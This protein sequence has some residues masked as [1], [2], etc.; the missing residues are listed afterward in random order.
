[1]FW[2]LKRLRDNIF[3]HFCGC[4]H[5]RRENMGEEAS[6]LITVAQFSCFS[7]LFF[8]YNFSNPKC[9]TSCFTKK[10]KISWSCKNILPRNAVGNPK[11]TNLPLSFPYFR[12]RG[13]RV[14]EGDRGLWVVLWGTSVGFGRRTWYPLSHCWPQKEE[15]MGGHD[16][17]LP[18]AA[19]QQGGA[20]LCSLFISAS[21]GAHPL[22]DFSFF[23]NLHYL[24]FPQ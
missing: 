11:G 19:G 15:V 4:F 16:P 8:F 17:H 3:S 1:M 2:S 6:L 14:I 24:S 12:Q 7:P 9:K 18:V 5:F 20:L 10:K 22:L 21:C 13:R 23:S